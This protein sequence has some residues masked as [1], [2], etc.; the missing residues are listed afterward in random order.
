[1]TLVPSEPQHEKFSGVLRLVEVSDSPTDIEKLQEISRVTFQDTFER[2]TEPDDMA[3]FL[4]SAYSTEELTRQLHLIGSRFF[5]L[6][7]DGQLAGYL[8]TNVNDAQSD[9]S[10]AKSSSFEVERLYILPA[11]KHRGLGTY[12]MAQAENMAREAGKTSMWLGVWEGN[13]PAQALYKKQGFEFVGKHVYRVGSDPQIDLL[14]SHKL[15]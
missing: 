8:K 7:A 15:S 10:M 11:F 14:M 12:L 6:Y 5:F 1:M 3:A 2:I 4:R 9:D 13:K